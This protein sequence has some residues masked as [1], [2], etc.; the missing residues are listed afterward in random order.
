MSTKLKKY[1]IKDESGLIEGLIT[2]LQT[3]GAVR[4]LHFGLFKVVSVK[5]RT[6]YN[7]K[8]RKVV[9]TLPYKSITF[10]PAKGL[11]DMFNKK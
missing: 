2:G 5:G 7:F 4:F 6:R 10:S 1:N 8:T 9:P 3:K 11:R